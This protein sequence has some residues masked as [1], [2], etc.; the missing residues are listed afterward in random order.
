[1][2]LVD[3][4]PGTKASIRRLEGGRAFLSRL[5]AL[6]FTPGAP[7][8]LVRRGDHGPV[9][10]SLRGVQVALGREEAGHVLVVPALNRP[11]AVIASEPKKEVLIALVGQPNVGKSTV[12]NYLTG[13]NQH[14][15]NWTGKTVDHKKGVYTYQGKAYTITDL[16]GT[17]SLT[18][19]SEEERLA[20]NFI[21]TEKPDL[22]IAVVDAATLERNLYLVAELLL[23]QT[24]LILALNMIDVAEQEGIHVEPKV[25]ESAL[26]V[27]V[28]AM[29]ATRGQGVDELRDVVVKMI[30]GEY[31]YQPRR[32]TILAAHQAVQDELI[33]IIH[34]YVPGDYPQDWVALKLLEGDEELTGIMKNSM[35]PE[36]WENVHT[37]LY[38][39]E[40]AILDIAGGR[41]EWIARMIR[42][43]VIE[44]KVT[45]V[46]MTA[47]LD[48]V[49]THPVYGTLVLVGI[50]GLVFWLTYS[51]GSPLQTLLSHLVSQLAQ[52]LRSGWTGV[53]AWLVEFVA[54]GV[55]NG[56]GM[57][58]TF[59]PILVIF[60]AILGLMEDTG[61]MARAAY[62]TDRWMHLMGLH[63]KSFLP[64]LLGFGCNVPAVMGTRI[65][66]SK[67]AR[68]LTTL[69]IPLVPCTARMAVLAVLGALFFGP[70]A[71]W[72]IW[73]LVGANILLLAGVGI[74]LH[75]FFFEDEH[76]PFIMEL[77]LY[78]LPNLRTI[79]L[80]VWQNVLGFIQKAGTTILLAS[81]VVWVFSYFPT[82]NV[83]T[84]YLGVVGQALGPLGALMG[85]PWPMM[86]ALLTSFVAKENTVATLGILYGSLAVL[87]GIISPPAGV[88]FL[89]F[90]LLFIPCIGTVA[91]IQQETHSLKLTAAS[92]GMMLGLSTGM[93]I[94]VFQIGRL[95]PL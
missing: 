31:D 63:G 14:V 11:A 89:V 21:I 92:I 6:G 85:L 18:A 55:L 60:F 69:L 74:V 23:L 58:L 44:P 53:P 20:R 72:V 25:L 33:E 48:R 16:P 30:A 82:G 95:L 79:G 26:G 64:I 61:Y 40:D 51:I 49:L 80:Y 39:H 37:L 65:I 1:M 88:A 34:K 27:P 15:G 87:P 36:A 68:L 45:R 54:G 57:V 76:V 56:I 43:A 7:V 12:F 70:S 83:R 35:P 94:L 75:H 62:L 91:A 17:Y 67:R 77:P 5:A 50:L 4:E 73:G 81:L 3:L 71:F 24:P 93:S 84:S 52:G 19:N 66:E 32:P 9:L 38:K 29:A 78:H 28:V 41:Y 86:V 59:V 8:T 10:V 47:R 2:Q 42:A 90:Q 22:V 46:G 13:M